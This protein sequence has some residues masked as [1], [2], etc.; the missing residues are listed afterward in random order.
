MSK[1]KVIFQL[2]CTGFFVILFGQSCE[3]VIQVNLKD[4]SPRL[5]VEG[6]ISNLSDS[7]IV[8]LHRSTDF[9]KPGVIPA[10]TGASVTLMNEQGQSYTMQD[11]QNGTYSLGNFHAS[12]GEGF[13]L[14]VIAGG[15]TCSAVTQM[16]DPVAIDSLSIQPQAGRN[17]RDRLLIYLRDP[18]GI[19]N[20]YQVKVFLHDSLLND[21]NSFA[22]YSDKYFN[23]K[24][25]TI[26]INSG[27]LGMDRFPAGDT[28]RVQLISLEKDMYDYFQVLRDITESSNFLSATTPSNPPNNLTNGALGYFSAWAISEKTLVVK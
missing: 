28:L 16:P 19:P 9:F 13:T 12:P 17:G 14:Q 8:M 18:S 10:V 3:D 26:G 20:Y 2:L 4:A 24:F 7:V 11:N 25:T 5:V 6:D 22:L 23:G 1:I 21:N 15:Q 27:R